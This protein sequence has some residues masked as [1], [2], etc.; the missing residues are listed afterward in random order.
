MIARRSS[1]SIPLSPIPSRWPDGVDIDAD[2]GAIPLTRWLV[3]PTPVCP[4]VR[5]IGIELTV[6]EDRPWELSGVGR[7][8]NAL[9]RR[10]SELPANSSYA[11]DTCVSNNVGWQRISTV[12]IRK[13]ARESGVLVK[14]HD[15][16]RFD[17]DGTDGMPPILECV[18][19]N[20]TFVLDA[21]LPDGDGW[22]IAPFDIVSEGNEWKDSRLDAAR[23]LKRDKR[24]YQRLEEMRDGTQCMTQHL[25]AGRLGEVVL[26]LLYVSSNYSAK[27]A[28]GSSGRNKS[29]CVTAS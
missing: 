4:T 2:G 15:D 24:K 17:V 21:E 27:Y 26:V 12:V 23:K 10:E 25:V 6:E 29:I 22:R 3:P 14:E 16:G 9:P 1:T 5:L 20:G 18:S 13:M 8:N 28:I 19:C 7:T 11:Y